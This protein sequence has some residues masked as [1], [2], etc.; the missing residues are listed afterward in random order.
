MAL[1]PHRPRKRFGQNFL[2]DPAVV[3]RIVRAIEPR[4]ADVTIEVGPGRGVLTRALLEHVRHLQ[5]IEIDRD[6]A[7]SLREAY[8]CERLQV[9]VGDALE[10]DFASAG[11][12]VRVV[13]NLPYN[14]SS[15]LLFR[16]LACADAIAD[17]HVM[18]QREVVERMIARPASA[19]YGRLTVMLGYRF[20]IERLF[21]VPAGAFRPQPKVESAFA[22][23]RPWRTLPAPAR[24]EALFARVVA[25]AFGQRRKTLRNALASIADAAQLREA[26]IDPQVRGE[27]LSVADFVRLANALHE[28]IGPRTARLE[29]GSRRAEM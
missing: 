9:H 22:R 26:G 5:V 2:V 8:A 14:I 27:T 23:L 15:P 6:L 24:D 18:L 1:A 11:P 12:S 7:A 4:A 29:P 13:G 19:A 21:R 10:F 28:T 25:A 3:Q 16:L 17:I 20:E